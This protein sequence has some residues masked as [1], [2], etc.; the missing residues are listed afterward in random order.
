MQ[1][2]YELQSWGKR[3][4]LP[5]QDRQLSPLLS[6]PPRTTPTA[7]PEH[8]VQASIVGL[9]TRYFECL[10]KYLSPCD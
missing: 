10:F 2:L 6:P 9:V 7:L 1:E 5:V 8:P 3:A 4:S